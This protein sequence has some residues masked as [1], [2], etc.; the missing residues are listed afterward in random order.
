MRGFSF[1]LLTATAV[2][3]LTTMAPKTQAQVGVEIECGV[4]APDSPYG[5]YDAAPY[6]CAPSGYYS[7][8]WF[9]GGVFIGTGPW[10]H[11]KEGFSMVT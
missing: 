5:Y 6:A 4:A 9:D 1:A 10:F 8:E 7:P 11:G 2:I 3:G